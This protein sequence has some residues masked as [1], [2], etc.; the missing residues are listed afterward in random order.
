MS[1]PDLDY[2]FCSSR[3]Q[4]LGPGSRFHKRSSPDGN[5]Y[6]KLSMPLVHAGAYR[7]LGVRGAVAVDGARQA[8]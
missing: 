2:D 7:D 3:A 6:F 1:A 8:A 5:D 4:L